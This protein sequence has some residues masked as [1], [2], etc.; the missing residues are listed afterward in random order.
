MGVQKA[1]TERISTTRRKGN[2]EE[3]DGIHGTDDV[4][5]TRGICCD[6]G[7]EGLDIGGVRR[8]YKEENCSLPSTTTCQAL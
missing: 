7:L 4:F 2:A 5:P 1:P 6:M 3:S 8:R